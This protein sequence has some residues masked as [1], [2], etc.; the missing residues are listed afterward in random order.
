MTNLRLIKELGRYP[1]FTVKQVAG[2][3]G[4][5]MDYTY[6]MVYRLK[7]SGLI[8]EIEKGKY[9]TES[10]PFKMASWIVWPSY[11]SCWAA[12]N[13]YGLTE[14]QPFTIHVVTTVKR[15]VKILSFGGARIEFLTFK[16]E[17]F[18]GF[19]RR[20]YGDSYLFIAEKEKALVDAV[21]AN[22]MSVE[23]AAEIVSRNRRKLS[24]RKVFHY[25]VLVKGL[26]KKLRVLLNDK[27]G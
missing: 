18:L 22:K 9:T 7:K 6:L 20:R 15:K 26:N 2:I 4:K 13:F 11:I 10:D 3:S 12:L 21:A 25:G 27:K 8:H 17:R 23:E 1:A 24:V 14:Q 16:R 5:G 19:V